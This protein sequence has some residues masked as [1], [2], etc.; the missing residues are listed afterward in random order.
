M[1]HAGD[2]LLARTALAKDEDGELGRGDEFH[3]FVEPLHCR[4]VAP[5][6]LFVAR[7]EGFARFLF[8]RG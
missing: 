4:A 5:H 1:D 3:M 7:H 8:R 6:P 2:I